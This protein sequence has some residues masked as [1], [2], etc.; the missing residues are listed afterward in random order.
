MLEQCGYLKKINFG[1]V[2]REK[3]RT[4][5]DFYKQKDV[6]RDPSKVNND[7]LG[8][9][10]KTDLGLKAE[11]TL[12]HGVFDGNSRHHILYHTYIHIHNR[13]TLTVVVSFYRVRRLNYPSA[14]SSAFPPWLVSD[15]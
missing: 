8:A 7:F 10:L 15:L 1:G 3:R 4:E 2:F 6:N 5:I 11:I 14:W 12:I 9:I 13:S